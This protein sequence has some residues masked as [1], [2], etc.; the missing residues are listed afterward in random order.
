M[1][2]VRLRRECRE[3]RSGI[4][5]AFLAQTTEWAVIRAARYVHFHDTEISAAQN[6][7]NK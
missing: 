5:P 2:R 3:Q 6:N 7:I 1:K 4:P